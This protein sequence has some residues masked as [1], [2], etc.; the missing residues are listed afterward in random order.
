MELDL[1]YPEGEL[2]SEAKLVAIAIDI[3]EKRITIP[4]VL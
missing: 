1:C 4:R 2:N 3:H